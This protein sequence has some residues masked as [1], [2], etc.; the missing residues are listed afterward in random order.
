[1]LMMS[2]AGAS[3]T[4]DPLIMAFIVSFRLVLSCPVRTRLLVEHVDGLAADRGR[5]VVSLDPA[6][7]LAGRSVSPPGPPPW[8][9]LS[10]VMKF[11]E[12]IEPKNHAFQLLDPAWTAAA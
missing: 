6:G 12:S 10:T 1:M 4:M 3:A 5:G 8:G 11:E 7:D 9:G 2:A